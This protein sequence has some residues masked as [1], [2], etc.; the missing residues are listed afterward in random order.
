[1]EPL[2]SLHYNFEEEEQRRSPRK[3]KERETS[4]KN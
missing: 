2:L 1:M 3:K 4:H